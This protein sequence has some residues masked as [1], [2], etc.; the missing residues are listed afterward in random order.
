MSRQPGITETSRIRR[1]TRIDRTNLKKALSPSAQVSVT[2]SNESRTDTRVTTRS[3][4][5]DELSRYLS[6]PRPHTLREAS[7]VKTPAKPTLAHSSA[8]VSPAGWPRWVTASA[9]ALRAITK[10]MADANLGWFTSRPIRTRHNAWGAFRAP[11]TAGRTWA[12]RA[13]YSPHCRASFFWSFPSG[14]MAFI[15]LY[16]SNTTPMKRFTMYMPKK[17]TPK[18]KY[19]TTSRFSWLA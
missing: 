2:K 12:R 4:T 1:K 8:C 18:K 3:N 19:H 6:P 14:V 7:K 11:L 9:A 15:S 13:A 16:W 5:S 17:A 10:K